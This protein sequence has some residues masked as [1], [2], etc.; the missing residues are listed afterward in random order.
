M[1]S[2][3]STAARVDNV[4]EVA[5]EVVSQLLC[6]ITAQYCRVTFVGEILVKM[7][8]SL[9]VVTGTTT[10]GPPFSV[11]RYSLTVPVCT[12][13]TRSLLIQPGNVPPPVSMPPTG[14]AGIELTTSERAALQHPLPPLLRA[15]YVPGVVTILVV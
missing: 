8:R 10:S 7:T 4:I 12:V 15:S 5:A 3:Y 11:Y 13:M 1:I 9:L 2:G 14:G 6:R